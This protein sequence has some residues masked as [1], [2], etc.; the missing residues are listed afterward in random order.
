MRSRLLY[1]A[2]PH[3]GEWVDKLTTERLP[4]RLGSGHNIRITTTNV[5]LDSRRSGSSASSR[6]VLCG[7]P[8]THN[9]RSCTN[10]ITVRRCHARIRDRSTTG[11]LGA[12]NSGRIPTIPTKKNARFT[13]EDRIKRLDA[14][15]FVWRVLRKKQ[16]G[17]APGRSCTND[18]W[19]IQAA[20]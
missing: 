8:S 7:M 10:D 9:E 6:V 11:T 13:A 12:Q 14:S 5:L 20:I 19:R 17:C 18:G 2:D 16:Y 4:R 15:G 3:L 1:K